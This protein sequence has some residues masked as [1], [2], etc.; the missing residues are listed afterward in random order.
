MSFESI[1]TILDSHAYD[2]LIGL[3]EDTWL[4]VKGRN[5]YDFATPEGRFE[6]A[7]DVSAFANADGGILI[8]GLTTVR[9]PAAK[10]ERITAHELCTPDEFTVE[11]YRGLI[12]EHVYPT[13]KDLA[14]ELLE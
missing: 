12:K 1:K 7:K 4:E 3:E 11:Q 5:P 14:N 8:V 2:A 13:I 10:T 6:L 9:S